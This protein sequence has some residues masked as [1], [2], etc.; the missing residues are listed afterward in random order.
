MTFQESIDALSVEI[1]ELRAARDEGWT[2]RNNNIMSV[3]D[4][5]ELT[6]SS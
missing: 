2:R 6:E 4:Y 3:Q 5:S 1:L